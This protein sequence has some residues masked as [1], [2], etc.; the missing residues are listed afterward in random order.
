MKKEKSIETMTLARFVKLGG[1]VDKLDL[2]KT[3]INFPSMRE[4]STKKIKSIKFS[5]KTNE[6]SDVFLV[7]FDDDMEITFAD[8]WI[9]TEVEMKLCKKYK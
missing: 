1:N 9:E 2:N 6:G 5:G 4:L 8:F 3:I 7:T